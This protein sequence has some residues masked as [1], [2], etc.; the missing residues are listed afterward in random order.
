MR[1]VCERTQVHEGDVAVVLGPGCVGLLTALVAKLEGARVV[2]TGIDKD[3][4]RLARARELGIDVVVNS[5]KDDLQDIVRGM[6]GGRGADIVYDCA[7]SQAS[8][9]TAWE[10]VKKEGTLVPLGIHPGKIETDF[11]KITMKELTVVGSYGYVYS[12]WQRTVRL[13]AE[14]RIPSEA[15]VSHEYP[16]ESFTD[17]F[18]ATQTGGGVKVIFNPRLRVG[19]HV[20]RE[21][22]GRAN[23]RRNSASAPVAA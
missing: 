23:E 21:R 20:E 8:L 19:A 4:A 12:T 16:L 10:T 18:E 3:A 22:A 9:S 1:A 14:R 7:G 17:A 11:N 15:L 6:T 2:I 13:L 5:G